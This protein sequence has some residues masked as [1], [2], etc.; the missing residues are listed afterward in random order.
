MGGDWEREREREREKVKNSAS[1]ISCSSSCQDRQTKKN[2]KLTGQR[3][4]KAAERS[5]CSFDLARSAKVKCD[6]GRLVVVLYVCVCTRSTGFG[7]RKRPKNWF[8]F[9]KKKTFW[10]SRPA[11]K[12]RKEMISTK[13]ISSLRMKWKR[14]LSCSVDCGKGNELSSIFNSLI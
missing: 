1:S 10:F 4:K 9:W 5:G 2:K 6:L 8:F 14:K 13:L 7:C 3:F 11:I 12:C